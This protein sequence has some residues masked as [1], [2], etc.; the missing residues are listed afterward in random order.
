[1]ANTRRP[2][3]GLHWM[4]A[5]ATTLISNAS[6]ADEPSNKS[7]FPEE[8]IQWGVQKGESCEDIAKA[9][10]GNVKHTPLLL[11]YNRI[12]CTRGAPL[13]PGLTLILPARVTE[14]PT[15]RIRS[16]EPAVESKPPGGSWGA[17][18]QGQP[19]QTNA[20]V[21]TREARARADIQFVDRTRIFMAGNTLVIIYGTANQTSVS[22]A[23][24]PVI[25][26]DQG[27]IKAALAA[28]RGAP[29]DSAVEISVNGGGRVSAS[30]ADTVVD[31]KKDRTT[32]AV[33]DGKARVTNAGK[34]V[35]VPTNYG[36]RFRGASPPDKPRPLP[37]AP[38]WDRAP[39][40]L[41]LTNGTG[42][43]TAT[44]KPD[45]SAKAYRVEIARDDKFEDPVLRVEMPGTDFETQN[46]PPGTYFTRVRV[47]DKDDFLGIATSP[48]TTGVA[49][50]S[51]TLGAGTIDKDRIIAN[52]YGTLSLNWPTGYE[53]ALD[54]GAFFSGPAKL[55]FALRRPEKLRVR[56]AGETTET[57]LNFGYT[58]TRVAVNE[59]TPKPTEG[60]KVT[61]R[62][63]TAAFTE[64]GGVDVAT[65]IKPEARITSKDGTVS[66]KKLSVDGSG[67][68]SFVVD[69]GSEIARIDIVDGVGRLLSGTE[70][71]QA[72]APKF[73]KGD[74]P[75]PSHIGPTLPHL[76]LSP[77]S[78]AVLVEPHWAQRWPNRRD[79]R[80]GL[81]GSSRGLQWE[82]RCDGRDRTGHARG[83]REDGR[84]SRRWKRPRP[85]DL[86]GRSA[87]R[88]ERVARST[89]PP[90]R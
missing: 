48:R 74:P 50:A 51:F 15:A 22:K 78:S 34:N 58:P 59:T 3:R 71:E 20:S 72:R 41:F 70:L 77:H 79:G 14:L 47:I 21:A 31:R 9:V 13:K 8:V 43:V 36:T 19:L 10:Y 53:G 54:D 26:L 84:S 35:E 38:L 39:P 29:K 55:D 27:E 89:R 24:P 90:R 61:S 75:R 1:M 52:D 37:P 73:E 25:E 63:F 69:G 56:R 32:I 30:S 65:R 60:T 45:P 67:L 66:T 4:F 46:L 18:G 87:K 76:A 83:A 62:S 40:E 42:T 57:V 5:A 86:G 88:R 17:A 85:R 12:L 82:C 49:T 81:R 2:T 16:L 33:F 44:W 64:T 80:S 23:P 28:M 7:A 68:S 6:F 11:R